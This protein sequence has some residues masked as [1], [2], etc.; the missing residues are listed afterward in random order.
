MKHLLK[1]YGLFALVT[2]ISTG[3]AAAF[4]EILAAA[5]MDLVARR[6][7]RLYALASDLTGRHGTRT[8]ILGDRS[9]RMRQ[10]SFWTTALPA[11]SAS[12]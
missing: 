3:I 9:R 1:R 12:W 8:D 2:G 4:A 7:G 10:T 5:G 11:I 6:S